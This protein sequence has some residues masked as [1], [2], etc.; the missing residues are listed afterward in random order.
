ME[1]STGG[2]ASSPSPVMWV[3]PAAS[4]Q[5]LQPSSTPEVR[6][7]QQE[8]EESCLVPSLRRYDSL[9]SL[10]SDRAVRGSGVGVGE[11][12]RR[13]AAVGGASDG[14]S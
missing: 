10:T 4:T 3:L 5:D 13:T 1:R 14:A 7:P 8:R 11:C 6:A 9:A 2:T 12:A